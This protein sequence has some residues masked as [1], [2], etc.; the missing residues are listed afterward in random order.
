MNKVFG[1]LYFQKEN[2]KLKLHSQTQNVLYIFYSYVHFTDRP[3]TDVRVLGKL[4]V[5]FDGQC[6]SGENITSNAN[7]IESYE[8]NFVGMINALSVLCR[9]E[10]IYIM[11]ARQPCS[12]L[13]TCV[14]NAF[15]TFGSINEVK[16]KGRKKRKL[17]HR[18]PIQI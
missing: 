7:V 18:T 8:L 3:K 17:N 2:V 4:H 15:K 9:H 11:G 1:V 6:T 13:G 16:K 5:L 10:H 14:K 12:Q